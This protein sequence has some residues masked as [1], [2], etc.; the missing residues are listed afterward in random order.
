MAETVN[1]TQRIAIKHIAAVLDL[2][3]ELDSNGKLRQV[4]DANPNGTLATPLMVDSSCPCC[5]S[6]LM[7]NVTLLY[8]K[9]EPVQE[10][11]NHKPEANLESTANRSEFP[12][13]L[14]SSTTLVPQY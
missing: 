11:M 12:F 4:S 5:S 3:L 9:P 1:I 10:E 13:Y 6:S 8:Q 2:T 14:N 7:V